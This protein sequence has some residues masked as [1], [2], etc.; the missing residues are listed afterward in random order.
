MAAII[1]EGV[2]SGEIKKVKTQLAIIT[3]IG[4][5]AHSF[6][7]QPIAEYV[8]GS[9]LEL[10]PARFGAFVTELF[11]DGLAPRSGRNKTGRRG[12]DRRA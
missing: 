4:M 9:Q 7:F 5:I 3:L 11:F 2:R 6:M 12:I 10:S 8:S 1:E